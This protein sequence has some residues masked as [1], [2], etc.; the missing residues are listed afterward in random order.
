MAM[1]TMYPPQ[2]N[3]PRTQLTAA[4]NAAATS[5]T[6]ED[7]SVLPATPNILSLGGGDDTELVKCVAITGN[8]LTVERGFNETT[9]KAW[10]IDTYIY[11]GIQAQDVSALQANVAEVDGKADSHAR[12]HVHDGP[13][14]L[15][16]EDIG[17]MPEDATPT[18]DAHAASHGS[19]GTDPIV[20]MWERTLTAAGWNEGVQ[21]LSLPVTEANVVLIQGA[22]KDAKTAFASAEIEV[23][24]ITGGLRFTATNTPDEDID[25]NIAAS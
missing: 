11:R 2:N 1:Q 7:A 3:G 21:N 9:P 22:S 25:I 15:T 16:P 5:I 18:P 24:H 12:R 13:D 17:A 4:I 6:V 10:D 14:P 23:T 20:R 8:I 19:G